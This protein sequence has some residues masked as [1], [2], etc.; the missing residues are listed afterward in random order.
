MD[1]LTQ[2]VLGAAV[3]EMVLGKKLG[4]KALLLGAIGGTL[5]D[6]DVLSN[7]INDDPVE[8]LRV[9]RA[10]S[11]SAFVHLLVSFPL[12]YLSKKWSKSEISSR[13]WYLFWST[14][15]VSHALLDCCTTYGTRLL[16]PFT[17]Y[18]VAF[19]NISVI[20]PLYTIP[21]LIFLLVMM[22]FKRESK[23][24]KMLLMAGVVLS[25]LYM[26]FTFALKFQAHRMFSQSLKKN[27]LNYDNL[28]STPTILNS[29]LWSATA[30]NNDSIYLAEYSFLKNEEPIQ[31]IGFARNEKDIQAF[32]CD[33]LQTVK[34]FADGSY[35]AIPHQG[36]S[37]TF[38]A[39]KF[40][41]MRY[42]V[43]VPRETFLFYSVFYKDDQGNIS[44]KMV[45]PE[46]INMKEAF[47]MLTQRIGI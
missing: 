34:W 19:N 15:L 45:E 2:I 26:V 5:P 11:H 1:S 8:Q 22:F 14:V 24:R 35:F 20:D 38:F 32:D 12:M 44:T 27:Q 21:F 17:N 29:I 39:I 30:F 41:R 10:Y 6:M 42:D 13:R 9:H 25:S 37:L 33:D 16:L 36:D 31:W 4:N 28:N 47:T 3:G 23:T 46:N 43:T 7:F 40:G 18:Q